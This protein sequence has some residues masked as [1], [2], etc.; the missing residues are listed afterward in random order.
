MTKSSFLSEDEARKKR[1]LLVG[2]GIGAALL[3]GLVTTLSLTGS[4]PVLP[5]SRS[6]AQ[7]RKSPA[8][9]LLALARSKVG[10]EYILGANVPKS[11]PTWAGPWDCAEFASW[12]VYQTTGRLVGV[13]DASANP[14]T[15][16]TWT[17]L[18]AQA[19]A[20]GA[21]GLRR[22]SVAEAIATP[23]AFLL[24]I[25]Q[26]GAYGH[27]A[28]SDGHGGTVEAMNSDRNVTTSRSAGRDWD[29]GILVNG[30]HS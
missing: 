17:G 23:G 22:V 26:Q 4:S 29:A 27:I 2:A 16:G 30:I 10:Q 7:K 12:L 1:E 15:A 28:I 20:K 25:P 21:Q 6:P 11:D 19:S 24:R 14:A 8:E 9:R 13:E 18:W 5:P 3:L